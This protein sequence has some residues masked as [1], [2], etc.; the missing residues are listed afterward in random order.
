[1]L[2]VHFQEGPQDAI[3]KVLVGFITHGRKVKY[4][5][6]WLKWLR[7]LGSSTFWSGYG[8]KWN[9]STGGRCSDFFHP[10]ITSD[11]YASQF[12]HQARLG[13]RNVNKQSSSLEIPAPFSQICEI[14]L[15]CF[16]QPNPGLQS[17][18]TDL[19]RSSKCI[20]AFFPLLPPSIFHNYLFPVCLVRF[21]AFFLERCFHFQMKMLLKQNL[22]L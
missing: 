12:L 21:K 15:G 17:I 22:H 3:S 14:F 5:M 18:V 8:L 11:L 16:K 4:I 2:C 9:F 7:L 10:P 1:M 6:R 20:K 13:N 19:R